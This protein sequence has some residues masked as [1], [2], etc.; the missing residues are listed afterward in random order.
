MEKHTAILRKYKQNNIQ[1]KSKS[2]YV[3]QDSNLAV[4][5]SSEG[6]FGGVVDEAQRARDTLPL[7]GVSATASHREVGQQGLHVGHGELVATCPGVLELRGRGVVTQLQLQRDTLLL[8]SILD[9][10][11]C[12]SCNM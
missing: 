9:R 5:L 10:D 2:K 8:R 11:I 1:T 12:I 4:Q 6:E 3:R 7:D